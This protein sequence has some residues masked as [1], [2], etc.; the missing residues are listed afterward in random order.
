M[1][2]RMMQFVDVLDNPLMLVVDYLDACIQ[3][4]CPLDK[5]HD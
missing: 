2:L 3:V 1:F 5:R 4:F